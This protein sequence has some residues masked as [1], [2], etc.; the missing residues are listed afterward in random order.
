MAIP[1]EAYQ[2]SEPYIF[3]SYAHKDKYIIYKEIKRLNKAGYKIWYDEGIQ[4]ANEWS[5]EIA[6]AI[7][8]C[9]T[10]LVFISP[11]AVKS[12]NVRNEINYALKKDK[13][14]IAVYIE[15]TTLPSGLELQISSIQAIMKFQL[16]DEYSSRKLIT[17]IHPSLKRGDHGQSIPLGINTFDLKVLEEKK[18]LSLSLPPPINS[19]ERPEEWFKIFQKQFLPLL[20]DPKNKDWFSNRIMK[21][22]Y[23]SRGL[24]RFDLLDAIL[25]VPPLDLIIKPIQQELV[26]M[27]GKA[28]LFAK[29]GMGKSRTLLYLSHWWIVKFPNSR[30][31]FID[32]PQIL[33][34]ID[35]NWLKQNLERIRSLNSS[36]NTLIIIDDI[37]SVI[38]NKY[39]QN[40]I[41][42]AGLNSY[43]LLVAYT[44]EEKTKFD[45]D[46]TL[47]KKYKSLKENLSLSGYNDLSSLTNSWSEWSLFFYEWISW[48]AKI[49]LDEESLNSWR[50]KFEEESKEYILNRYNSPWSIVISL[51]FLKR[52]LN[53][54]LQDYKDSIIERLLYGLIA[55]LYLKTGEIGIFKSQ[56][57]GFLREFIGIKDLRYEFGVEWKEGIIKLVESLTEHPKPLLPP[58]RKIKNP[59][60]KIGM[61]Y[62]IDFYH[63]EWADY[64]CKNLLEI[65]MSNLHDI[66]HKL[67]QSYLPDIYQLWKD[68]TQ[69]LDHKPDFITWFRDSV[70]LNLD[71]NGNCKI[72]YIDLSNLQLSKLPESV[73]NLKNLEKL[74]LEKNN[75][76]ELPKSIEN[77]RNL[78]E[79]NLDKNKLTSLPNSIINLTNLE[80]LYIQENLLEFLPD[81]INNLYNL[82]ALWLNSNELISLPKNIVYLKNLN[83]LWLSHNELKSL[84]KNFGS[85][86]NLEILRLNDNNLKS[87]PTSFRN[88]KKLKGLV[89]GSNKFKKFPKPLSKLSRLEEL[90]IGWNSPTSLPKNIENLTNLKVLTA[91]IGLINSLPKNLGNLINLKELELQGNRLETLPE[92]IGNLK[93]L[94]KLNLEDNR[95][96]SIPRSIGDLTNLKVLKLNK[97]NLRKI[98]ESIYNLRNLEEVYLSNNL[99][100]FIPEPIG[101]ERSIEELIVDK[102]SPSFY[103]EISSPFTISEIFQKVTPEIFHSDKATKF[104]GL[105][106]FI[107]EGDQP[108]ALYINKGIL[109]VKVEVGLKPNLT[110]KTTKKD[111][112]AMLRGIINPRYLY[113]TGGISIK[114][115]FPIIAIIKLQKFFDFEAIPRKVRN[116]EKAAGIL[117]SSNYETSLHEI[118]QK[119]KDIFNSEKAEGWEGNII[120]DIPGEPYTL[121]VRGEKVKI[122]PEK[123]PS[124]DLTITIDKDDLR[125]LAYG[126][127]DPM[128]GAGSGIIRVDNA[129]L[130]IKFL[131]MFNFEELRFKL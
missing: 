96:S 71:F 127:L 102:E 131:Q 120:F 109:E 69:V 15:E 99:R 116:M 76:I 95:L 60:L 34:D 83:D 17:S 47:D 70:A 41:K 5:E 28:G 7:N 86:S 10:F 90:H 128:I 55:F 67:F 57:L 12:K 107:I 64:V 43:T 66:V 81:D 93:S 84:P 103:L 46:H 115:K 53:E 2:G 112:F 8:N 119:M 61:E 97:N 9:S 125:D 22:A 89:L 40:L 39:V 37:H 63:R 25:A 19:K 100:L 91:F 80:K 117:Y 50:I 110:I 82:K 73:T 106:Q 13:K 123:V 94:E 23:G 58:F 118:F 26:E 108:Q 16:S 36:E 42:G 54:F 122:K 56:L 48:V 51:G 79:L 111:M 85:L 65:E 88:L 30:V 52:A 27:N 101:N 32:T 105:I 44:E 114:P 68:L 121:E 24:E 21:L 20:E 124:A 98:P 4:P 77:L 38:D 3:V 31:F 75:L 49:I 14:F 72:I 6:V 87:L 29:T 35:W 45:K 74:F 129:D 11:Q 33:L 18:R 92:S 59:N 113:N 130:G 1:F 78:N 104:K 126:L 62:G